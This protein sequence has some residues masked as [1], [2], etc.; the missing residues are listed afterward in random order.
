MFYQKNSQIYNIGQLKEWKITL[1]K[2]AIILKSKYYEINYNFKYSYVQ[3]TI[4]IPE[5]I[6]INMM[7]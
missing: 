6:K 7:L 2:I 4:G 3:M 1:W 5:I